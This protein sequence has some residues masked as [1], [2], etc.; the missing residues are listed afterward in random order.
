MR[1]F[2]GETRLETDGGECTLQEGKESETQHAVSGRGGVTALVLYS[3]VMWC[4][5]H[6]IFTIFLCCSSTTAV[7]DHY[8]HL[9]PVRISKIV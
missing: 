7:V 3:G 5:V 6:Q 8:Q 2:D 1:T 9:L 4:G